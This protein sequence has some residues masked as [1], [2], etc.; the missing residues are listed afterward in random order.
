MGPFTTLSKDVISSL[1]TFNSDYMVSGSEISYVFD[2]TTDNGTVSLK[3]DMSMVTK[4]QHMW[5]Q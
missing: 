5:P 2:C 3:H 1:E 4:I